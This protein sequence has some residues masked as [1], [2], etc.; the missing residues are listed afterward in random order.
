MMSWW[1]MTLF[2]FVAVVMVA[3]SYVLLMFE[4][5]IA[6]GAVAVGARSVRPSSRRR[7]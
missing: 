7:R 4:I 5:S 3:A 6:A 2:L 1:R